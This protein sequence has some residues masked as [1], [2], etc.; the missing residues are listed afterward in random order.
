VSQPDLVRPRYREGQQLGVDDLVTEQDYL[1]ATRRR[2]DI[3]SHSWGIAYGLTLSAQ[4]SGL[5]IAPGYAVDALGRP[6]VVPDPLRLR[7]TDLPS[8]PDNLDIWL[9][10][11]EEEVADRV[12]EDVG[13]LVLSGGIGAMAAV[14][15]GRLARNQ[16]SPPYLP[17]DSQLTYLDAEGGS[18]TAQTG[19]ELVLDADPLLSVRIPDA[20]GASVR[21]LAVTAARRTT[22]NG[23]LVTPNTNL[24]DDR[25]LRFGDPVPAPEQALPWRWYQAELL[26]DGVVTGRELRIE[27]G[28]PKATD[29]PDWYRFAVSTASGL[30]PLAVDAGGTTTIGGDLTVRGPLVFGPLTVDPDDPRLADALLG[31]WVNAVDQ[32][33]RAVDQRF[34]GDLFDTTSLTVTLASAPSTRSAQPPPTTFDYA[35]TVTDNSTQQITDIT[36]VAMT[37]VNADR[38]TEVLARIAVLAPGANYPLTHSVTLPGAGAIVRVEVFTLGLLPGGRISLGAADLDWQDTPPSTDHRR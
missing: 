21:R 14:Y 32:S 1:I 25:A 38:T 37:T 23:T 4:T 11:Q 9:R 12:T 3:T 20:T 28:A 6:L 15:L 29:V 2:H 16:G 35:V 30:A 13:V 26:T 34:S 22:V 5:V 18:V 31:T 10:Y 19:T 24:T 8:G 17:A 27:V 36:V 7:W 33:S